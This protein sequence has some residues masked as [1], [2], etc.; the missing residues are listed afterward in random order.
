VTVSPL[1]KWAGGK[2][3]FLPVASDGI[4]GYLEKSG[5][6]YFE[7]FLGGAAMALSLGLPDMILS[8]AIEELVEFYETVRDDP[9]D[10]AWML[11]A[12]AIEGVDK[13]N[14]L[15]VRD[16]RPS[17]RGSRA[18]RLLYLNRLCFNG[19]YRV[20]K[21]GTFNV[22][23]GDQ[24]YRESV[25]KRKSRDAIG[26]LFPHKGKIEAV[27]EALREATICCVD[28]ELVIEEAGAND[29]L[30][31]DPPYDEGYSSYT[32]KKFTKADQERLAEALYYAHKRGAAI[33]AHNAN[34]EDVN[35]W[36]HEWMTMRSVDER[37]AINS[38]TANRDGAPC[39]VATNVPE[40]LQWRTR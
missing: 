29:L 6:N 32:A 30:Y 21:G 37:R 34:T 24:A 4:R 7:P 33:I 26:S 8:D 3:W 36:Y 9:A 15:R 23:Y 35:Y 5:G 28:F 25:I 27:S 17:T 14:Y 20:N 12:Y 39:V 18:A 19:V 40:L 16:Y 1:L 2:R 31:V 13:E 22:P 38:D 11:S 10:V